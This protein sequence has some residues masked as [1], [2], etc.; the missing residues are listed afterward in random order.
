[1]HNKKKLKVLSVDF[2]YFQ[3]VN[4][5]TI[6]ECYPDGH[7][8]GTELSC[9]VWAGRYSYQK[10]KLLKVKADTKKI[11]E[12][13]DIIRNMSYYSPIMVCNSHKHCYDFIEN[14]Y[15]SDK[16][17]GIE[18]VNID[19]HHD[20]FN[21]NEE[22]DCGNW[23][24]HVVKDFP[25]EVTWIC[26]PISKDVYGIDSSEFTIVREDFSEIQYETFDALFLCRSDM[27][28]PPHLDDK[29]QELFHYICE[30]FSDVIKE[31]NIEIPRDVNSILNSIATK[32]E[33][34]V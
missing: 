26:N 6:L 25:C 23:I 12:L 9:I 27:W 17:E 7:D 11:D 32:K 20:L 30:N 3:K 4:K 2:D 8:L 28:L 10:N 18:L 19:M 5:E 33:K 34:D 29:F 13:E 21:D 22:L 15:N 1:M 24:G 16:Y 14:I 31:K